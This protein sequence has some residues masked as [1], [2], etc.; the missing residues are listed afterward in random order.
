MTHVTAT[1]EPI[2]PLLD[3]QR[4]AVES[5]ARFTWN[6]WSRQIGKSFAFSLKR[7]LRAVRTGRL[8]V[9]L[10]AGE[11]QS[12]EL[13]EKVRQHCQALRIANELHEGTFFEGTTDRQLEL[14]LPNR[15]RIIAL[16][17]NPNTARGFTGDVFLD[18]FAMHLHDREI[19]AALL[20]T[21]LRGEG[22]LDIA[23]TPKGLSNQ[24]A[25]LRDNAEFERTTVTIHD[26]LRDGLDV[27]VE[28]IHRATDDEQIWQQE[29]LCE[30][31]D[32]S[33]AFLTYEQIAACED[34]GLALPIRV[35]GRDGSGAEAL[36]AAIAAI[37]E[38]GE[39][40]LGYDVGR[41]RDFAV[42]WLW[43][44][45][46]G[47][48]MTR[49]VG[50]LDNVRFRQ[51]SEWL[52]RIL[53]FRNVR[54]ASIDATGMGMQLAEEMIEDFGDWRIDAVNFSGSVQVGATSTPVKE[55]L[56]GQL[57]VKVEDCNA[58][59]P[60]C[61]AVREDWRSIEKSVTTGG[62]I[63]YHADRNR[64]GHADRFW[65]AGLG[66]DAS[67][68]AGGR[69]VSAGEVHSASRSRYRTEEGGEGGRRGG[70][71][72]MARV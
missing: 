24:F 40:Y 57:R 71:G 45:V 14:S 52:H 43:E 61:Q 4:R 6:N 51:Q 18:E 41:K 22:Q 7:L 2:V 28:A 47:V 20:P 25:R 54:R 29:F 48:L 62:R 8:Q 9:L 11:R 56:A 26:A 72:Q 69:P 38:L 55:K 33:S 5:A 32:E 19:W 53:G 46:G 58:R 59:I 60:A 16:P 70:R 15:G 30:F 23:S 27:D 3:Y 13:M 10:S 67:I 63:R 37:G 50:E 36:E 21:V 66:V 49:L 44:K 31:L 12:R 39:C 42:P 34:A 17:A 68:E 1:A 64:W 35:N 65:A